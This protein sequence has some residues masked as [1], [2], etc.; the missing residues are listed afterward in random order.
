MNNAELL[1]AVLSSMTMQQKNAFKNHL[2]NEGRISKQRLAML[3]TEE[4]AHWARDRGAR[5][6][7]QKAKQ[8]NL[9]R[10]ESP[11]QAYHRVYEARLVAQL[12]YLKE[13]LTNG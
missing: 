8:H 10:G 2:A 7:R 12:A 3:S 4:L 11:M 6:A 9:G 13:L 1:K 5:I